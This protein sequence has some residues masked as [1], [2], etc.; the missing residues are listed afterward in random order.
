M[1]QFC[2]NF[3]VIS[4]K[5]KKKRSSVFHRPISLCH[6]DGLSEPMSPL[7]GSLQRTGPMMGPFEAHGLHKVHGPRGHCS[8]LSP[9]LVGPEYNHVFALLIFMPR[10]N[11][12]NFYQNRPKTELFLPKKY[13]NFESLGLH[14]QTSDTVPPLIAN[15]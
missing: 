9:P 6:F 12:I 14:P 1:L 10:F 4:K 13:K 3:D 5:K 11:S 2:P 7:L 8:P 15:F